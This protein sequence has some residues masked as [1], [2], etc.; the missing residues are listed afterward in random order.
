[1]KLS[2]DGWAKDE[3]PSG[4]YSTGA[5]FYR[6]RGGARLIA[7]LSTTSPGERHEAWIS[8][9]FKVVNEKSH[10]CHNPG[11]MPPRLTD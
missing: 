2:K 6:N 10:C 7:G 4:G 5:V 8:A 3:L 9:G 1:L 11:Q